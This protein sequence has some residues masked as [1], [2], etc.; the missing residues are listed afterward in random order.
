MVVV[1]WGLLSVDWVVDK[2]LQGLLVV[3]MW[4]ESLRPLMTY[5]VPLRMTPPV[6]GR[7][8]LPV[9]RI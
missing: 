6:G 5:Q 1:S 9:E 3:G 7:V 2:L 4:W 8:W